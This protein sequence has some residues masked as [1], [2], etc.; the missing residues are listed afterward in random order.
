MTDYTEVFVGIDTSKLRNAIAIAEAGR[1][2]EIRYLGE[3]ENTQA[4]TR[5]LV[6]KLSKRYGKLN[7]CYEAGPT[8]YGLHRWLTEL[9]QSNIVVAPSLIPKRPGDRVKTNRRDAQNL[10][11][12]L[13]AGDLT[14]VWVP[15]EAHEAMRDLVR[16]RDAAVRDL[17]AKRQQLTSF[18][19]RHSLSFPGKTA[20]TKTHARW[21]ASLKFAHH[22]HRLVLEES[23]SAIHDAQER[24][25][26]IEHA[27]AELA[28]EW[29]LAPVVDAV[30]AMRGFGF[31]AAV[32]FISEVGDLSRFAKPSQLMGY[33]GLTPSEDS[34]GDSVKR[35][36]ITKAGNSRARRTLVESAWT[37]RFPARLGAAK[38]A[39]V[40]AQPKPVAEIAWKAQTRLCAR[41]R[42]LTAKG[43]KQAVA[44]TAIARELAAFIWAIAREVPLTKAAG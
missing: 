28:P 17:R 26:R 33:L 20:W 24:I 44:V 42:A 40:E 6:A 8:G 15:D 32:S 19:L 14:A 30:Q 7:F 5:K 35:G 38:R 39:T 16:A 31:I 27:I 2:G 23:M 22:A 13:R 4:A 9:G 29:S 10:A 11:R 3:I 43:K 21:L 34:T 25:V 36:S 12:L 41:Y 18:L 37:Y 1:N